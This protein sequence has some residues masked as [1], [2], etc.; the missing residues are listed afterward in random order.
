MRT[1]CNRVFARS[2]FTL[3]EYLVAFAIIIILASIL[4]P[5]L[6]HFK[7]RAETVACMSHMRTVHGGLNSYLVDT[8]RWPQL[9]GDVVDYSESEYYQWWIN[10]IEP[11]GI[12]EDNWLCP[13]DK[14]RVEKFDDD[15]TGSYIP[16][17]F[18]GLAITPHRWNQPWLV[19]R[20]DLHGK[21]AHVAMPDGSINPS[22]NPF[23]GMR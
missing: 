11:Y 18:D 9:P 19:E 13:S 14:V 3:L 10:V 17:A 5:A 20:G 16:T 7:K 15:K 6:R 12:S 22:T 2:G 4:F 21:G 8:G 1:K 23:G